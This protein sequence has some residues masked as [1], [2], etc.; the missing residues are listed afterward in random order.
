MLLRRPPCR[1]RLYHHPELNP[2]APMI[3]LKMKGIMKNLML[4][5]CLLAAAAL[6]VVSSSAT[7][8]AQ[9]TVVFQNDS[10]VKGSVLH[11]ATCIHRFI[12][13]AITPFMAR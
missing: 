10:R 5:N 13:A 4:S 12:S 11:V 2:N 6:S 9:G 1:R 3:E 7:A 8:P